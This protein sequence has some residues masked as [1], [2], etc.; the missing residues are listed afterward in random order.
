MLRRI[1]S[2]TVLTLVF[3]AA[4]HAQ[5]GKLM[6]RVLGPDG[7][8]ASFATV[9]VKKG[10]LVVK[11]T[12]TDGDGYYSI[13]PLDPGTYNVEVKYLT[14]TKVV[15]NVSVLAGQTRDLDVIVDN[16]VTLT[17]VDIIANP[18][19]EKDPA[20]VTTISGED[21]KQLSVVGRVIGNLK[22]F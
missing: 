2:F 17:E 18:V 21:L 13:N 20:V 3:L 10:E 15:E 16:T 19:F 14:S 11:G 9:I 7:D 22:R 5:D 4:A 12:N 6:G 1:L 8:P